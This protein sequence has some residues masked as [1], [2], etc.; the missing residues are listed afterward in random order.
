MWHPRRLSCKRSGVCRPACQA[1]SPILV[2]RIQVMPGPRGSGAV[3]PVVRRCYSQLRI[4]WGTAMDTARDAAYAELVGDVYS[5]GLDS[6]RWSNVL[7][8]MASMVGS[9]AGTIFIHDFES[10][11]ADLDGTGGNVAAFMGFEESALA[12]YANYYSGRN[13][14]IEAE[15]ALPPGSAV[16]SSMLLPESRLL[17]TEFYSD[18]LKPQD[19]FYSLG[20]VV[21]KEEARA[22]KLSFL[23]SERDGAYGP[24]E[25]LLMRRLMPHLQSS[26]ATHRRLYQLECLAAGALGALD[27]LRHGVVL[28]DA[29]RKVLHANSA[30]VRISRKSAA[31]RFGARGTIAAA[32]VPATERLLRAIEQSVLTGTGRGLSPGVSIRLP[33]A[34][35]QHLH[36]FVAALPAQLTPF[37]LGAAAAVF[38]SDPDAAVGGLASALQIVYNMTPAEAALTEALCNGLT[39]AQ[40]AEQ[41]GVSMNTVRTQM[42]VAASKA[43]A[44]RQADLVRVVLTGPAML[45]SIAFTRGER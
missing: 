17:R 26:V 6:G 38:C 24:D 44:K 20:S 45:S 28:I 4:F 27:S 35:G 7:A 23:R 13:V 25:L 15:D 21:V 39:L 36:V 19:F 41:R 9:A 14:W 34:N 32:T 8:R 37:G 2:M 3:A 33:A 12:S 42:K 22:V 5:A 1:K 10:S 31:M 18:W 16:T 43:G 30:A 11:S 29:S 40:F